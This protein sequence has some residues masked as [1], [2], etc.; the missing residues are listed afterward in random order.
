MRNTRQ[1]ASALEGG[2]IV[3]MQQLMETIRAL[4]QAVVASK[5]DQD[6]ILAKVQAEQAANQDQFQVDLAVSRANNEELRRA[7]EELRR[8]RARLMLF[9]LAIM[10]TVIP[11]N[12]MG[13]KISFTGV[14]N[15][16]AHIMVFHTQMLISGG[17]DAMHC[18]FFM[19]TFSGKFSTLFREQYIVN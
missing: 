12:F 19:S 15:L 4:Q 14:E 1:G 11:A 7:N 3:S 2:D 10:E 6:K 16:E 18:K 5:A 13:P 8:V 9:S 17:T